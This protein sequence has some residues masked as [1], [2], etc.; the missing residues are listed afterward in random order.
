ME[1]QSQQQVISL[2]LLGNRPHGSAVPTMIYPYETTHD[3]RLGNGK[4]EKNN[5]VDEASDSRWSS[6]ESDAKLDV[7]TEFVPD[8]LDFP[9]DAKLDVG[10]LVPEDITATLREPEIANVVLTIPTTISS[11]TSYSKEPAT[12][13][14]PH[15][16][17]FSSPVIVMSSKQ[18][19]GDH[20]VQPIRYYPREAETSPLRWN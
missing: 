16:L 12:P 1:N 11:P 20:D 9:S 17:E 4:L 2:R 10:K 8:D 3:D 5:S 19:K 18:R 14:Y 7:V 13:V 6:Q 15:N